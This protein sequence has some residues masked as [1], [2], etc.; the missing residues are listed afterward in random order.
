MYNDEEYENL[1]R[2]DVNTMRWPNAE[3][4]DRLTS[5]WKSFRGKL[6]SHKLILLKNTNEYS[7]HFIISVLWSPS[8]TRRKTSCLFASLPLCLFASL[9][10]CRCRCCCRCRCRC[11]C[12]CRAPVPLRLFEINPHVQEPNAAH[13]CQVARRYWNYNGD[14]FDGSSDP[15]T[16]WTRVGGGQVTPKGSPVT[17]SRFDI[18]IVVAIAVIIVVASV[19]DGTSLS[20]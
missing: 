15:T 18:K 13:A 14:A 10:L 12:R 11:H 2:S 16:Q 17:R 7:H 6:E 3:K 8:Q 19:C 4:E 9:P 20:L 5:T 1:D